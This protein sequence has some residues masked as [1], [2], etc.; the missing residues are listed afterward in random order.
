VT[1]R[2]ALLSMVK[3]ALLHLAYGIW[4]ETSFEST[5]SFPVES[6]AVAT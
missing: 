2:A 5:L 3:S 6:T 1:P 4:A